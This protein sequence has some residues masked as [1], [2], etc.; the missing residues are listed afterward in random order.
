MKTKAD[1]N[2]SN[3]MASTG[4]VLNKKE[5]AASF[6]RAAASYDAAAA[7]QRSIAEHLL[8]LL[9][10]EKKVSLV[11]EESILDLGAGTGF[12]LPELT[13]RLNP[14]ALYAVDLA[15][16]MMLLARKKIPQSSELEFLCADAEALPLADQSITSV[17]SSF[18]LQWC[19]NIDDAFAE[20]HRVLQSQGC[21]ALS[22]PTSGTLHELKQAWSSVD[23]EIHINQFPKLATIVRLLNKLGFEQV[24]TQQHTIQLGFPTVKALMAELKAIGAH[25]L[26]QERSKGLLGKTKFKQLVKAYEA[27]RMQQ[28]QQQGQLPATYQVVYVTAKKR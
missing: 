8:A 27:F 14:K 23:D 7:M 19:P 28:G 11:G 26:N 9:L 12:M 10:T 4:L 15:E 18:A 6:S 24:K 2:L 17:F 22:L 5:V 3:T 1:S 25:N 16:G 13:Q 21:F 20:V